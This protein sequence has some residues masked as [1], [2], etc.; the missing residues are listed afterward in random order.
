MTKV[1]KCNNSPDGHPRK[2][3]FQAD[4]GWFVNVDIEVEQ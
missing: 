1:I 2:Q 3:E 4:F